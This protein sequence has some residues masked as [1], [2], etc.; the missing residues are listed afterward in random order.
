VFL[1]KIKKIKKNNEMQK[2]KA[3]TRNLDRS[4]ASQHAKSN[5]RAKQPC[6]IY[7]ASFYI[8]TSFLFFKFSTH[9]FFGS[10]VA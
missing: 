2:E 7:F 6:L 3:Q 8:Y 10:A 1:A 5:H 9:I 4:K